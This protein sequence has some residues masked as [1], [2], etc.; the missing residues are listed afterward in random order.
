[1]SAGTI[2]W[3]ISIAINLIICVLFCT[4]VYFYDDDK[5]LFP[6]GVSILIIGLGLIKYVATV[7]AVLLIIAFL[8][9]GCEGDIYFK[10]KNKFLDD[11]FTR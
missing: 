11:L 4:S 7:V 8:V 5:K 3:L 2:C 6:V 9:L 1:M 10:F